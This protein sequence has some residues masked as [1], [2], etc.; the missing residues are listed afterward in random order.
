MIWGAPGK[1][2]CSRNISFRDTGAW[3]ATIHE[4]QRVRHARATTIL[5]LRDSVSGE[6]LHFA[7]LLKSLFRNSVTTLKE[8]QMKRHLQASGTRELSPWCCL[9]PKR[10]VLSQEGELDKPDKSV[11]W[12]TKWPIRS[13]PGRSYYWISLPAESRVWQGED[14]QC[15]ECRGVVE[16]VGWAQAVLRICSN[17]SQL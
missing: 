5:S 6:T 4:S 8:R 14:K 15:A 7:S 12:G 11:D 13:F 1:P 16:G 10:R 2:P 17:G 3:Q 9:Q